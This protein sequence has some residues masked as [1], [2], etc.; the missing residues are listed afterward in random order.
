MSVLEK[1]LTDASS[2]LDGSLLPLGWLRV[3]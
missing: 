1:C 2:D 3:L